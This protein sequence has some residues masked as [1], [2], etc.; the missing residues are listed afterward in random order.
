MHPWPSVAAQPACLYATLPA[1]NA[2]LCSL[3]EQAPSLS[4]PG[5][6]CLQ[7]PLPEAA[8]GRPVVQLLAASP[9]LPADSSVQQH[10]P[11]ATCLLRS[12]S[13]SST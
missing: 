9:T 2:L 5:V 13:A 6:S 11:H 3:P 4:S 1:L 8:P 12:R 7:P 10:H